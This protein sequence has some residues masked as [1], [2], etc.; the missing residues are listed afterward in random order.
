[1]RIVLT[2]GYDRAPHAMALAESLRQAGRCPV[3]VLV[4]SAWEPTRISSV[5]RQGG[6]RALAAKGL[7]LFGFDSPPANKRESNDLDRLTAALG[8][9]SSSL[10]RWARSH[11]VE[12]RRVPSL[13]HPAAFAALAGAR[14]S[15]VA[16]AGGGIIRQPF[17]DA[18]AGMVFNAHAGP[19]PEVRGM[20]ACE[21]S[22]LLGLRP[23]VTIHLIDRGIDTGPVLSRY[24]I[25]LRPGDDIAALRARSAAIGAEGLVAVLKNTGLQPEAQQ[26]PP[27][28]RQ[29]YAMAPALRE[30][31][32][33]R[34]AA[35]ASPS[36]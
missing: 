29:C 27:R 15:A 20:N 32:Q 2:A 36:Q 9:A 12:Y 31:L 26:S 34:L 19:L 3:L 21:W 22:L 5:L 6:L 11:G 10:S 23:C 8:V 7:Q 1:M 25:E 30:L 24:P 14:V 4:V 18:V 33:A 13:N 28:F 35:R 16:Y 17:L